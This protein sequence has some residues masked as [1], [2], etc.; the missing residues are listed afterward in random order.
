[1][2]KIL[3]QV[4]NNKLKIERAFGTLNIYVIVIYVRA[5]MHAAHIIK[6]KARYVYLNCYMF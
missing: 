1:M 4:K 2:L 6:M 5:R 3:A